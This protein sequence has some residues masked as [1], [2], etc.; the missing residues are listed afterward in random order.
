MPAAARARIR[1]A[2]EPTLAR[3]SIR[4]LSEKSL[5]AVLDATPSKR[6]RKSGA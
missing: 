1:A 2:D 6:A 3:W 4:V 5:A